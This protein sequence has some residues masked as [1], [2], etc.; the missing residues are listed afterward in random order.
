MLDIAA[1]CLVITALLAYLNHRFVRL[2]TTIGVMVIALGLSLAIVA[3]DAAGWIHALRHYEESLLRSIHF[4]DVLMQG[5]LSLLLFAA[6]LHVD[7]SELKAHRWSVAA[8]ALVG[9]LLSTLLVGFG[10]W[11]ALPW[12]GTSAERRTKI[13]WIDTD[14]LE[15]LR[16]S[17]CDS[18]RCAEL[19]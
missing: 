3:L 9:T 6:A 16:C 1:T 11:L 2:P 12:V 8:L 5:M 19:R 18:V 7:L 13:P 15:R 14:E 17:G 4:S 10:L